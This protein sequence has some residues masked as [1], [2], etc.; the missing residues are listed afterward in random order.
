MIISE[1][2]LFG[3]I[4]AVFL[5]W[6][7]WIGLVSILAWSL[8]VSG[9][10]KSAKQSGSLLTR[11][12]L[13][14]GELIFPLLLGCFYGLAIKIMLL[15]QKINFYSEAF[16]EMRWL[17]IFLYDVKNVGGLWITIFSVPALIAFM[18]WSNVVLLRTH[19]HSDAYDKAWGIAVN[20][21][22]GVYMGVVVF[23]I[24]LFF[25]PKLT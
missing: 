11:G 6:S 10:F 2:F 7:F 13:I 3:C 14:R 20:L 15:P 25:L 24:L 1:L 17:R 5:D 12:V 18:I 16:V 8:V 21:M 23:R 9:A 22:V 19:K 4:F